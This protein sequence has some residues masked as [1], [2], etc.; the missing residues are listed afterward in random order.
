MVHNMRVEV[1]EP[2]QTAQ[3]SLQRIDTLSAGQ[4]V[5]VGDGALVLKL[6]DYGQYLIRDKEFNLH[7][8]DARDLAE[9]GGM[10]KLFSM[11]EFYPRVAAG[12]KLILETA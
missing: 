8:V 4:A 11:T 7:S 2:M 9:C 3:A 6:S 12:T 10:L 5:H 1:V